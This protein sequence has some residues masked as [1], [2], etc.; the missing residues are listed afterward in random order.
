MRPLDANESPG[1]GLG[2]V[3]V[4]ANTGLA[5]VAHDQKDAT[6]TL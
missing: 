3:Q 1:T 6:S 2:G 5:F 4:K